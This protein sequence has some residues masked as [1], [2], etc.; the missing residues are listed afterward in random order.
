MRSSSVVM[1]ESHASVRTSLELV[2]NSHTLAAL[3]LE[4]PNSGG[5]AGKEKG[6]KQGPSV[7]LRSVCVCF[8]PRHTQEK[9]G[10]VSVCVFVS[11]ETR[12]A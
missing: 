3:T 2:N 7:I 5:S 9:R 4:T 6:N 11:A 10:G 12:A 8:L 1:K